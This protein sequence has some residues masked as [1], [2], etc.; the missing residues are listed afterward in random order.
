MAMKIAVSGGIASGKTTAANCLAKSCGDFQIVSFGAAIRYL[1]AR[2]GI[3]TTRKALQDRG[4]Q[5]INE[6]GAAGF[7]D[8]IIKVCDH[9]NWEGSVILD[10]FRHE[11][12]LGRFRELFD[13]VT[14]VFCRC[15]RS[16]RISRIMERDNKSYEKAVA[17]M[18]H[19]VERR[20][21]KLEDLADF[22]FET[23]SEEE[24][25]RIR[26]IN[27]VNSRR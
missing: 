5:L 16:I 23:D 17:E 19:E 25:Q 20:I 7:M 18:S 27:F 14:H 4:A 8:Y 6:L 15:D 21:E 24:E 13:N 10:G 3:D 12:I 26:L 11:E 2:E 9:V 1:N 22:V